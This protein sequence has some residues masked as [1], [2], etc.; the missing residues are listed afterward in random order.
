MYVNYNNDH[1]Q[2]SNHDII[3]IM[4]IF[5]TALIMTIISTESSATPYSQISRQ[6]KWSDNSGL[7]AWRWRLKSCVFKLEL[8]IK[9]NWSNFNKEN[10]NLQKQFQQAVPC[11]PL[12]QHQFYMRQL[13]WVHGSKWRK[14]ILKSVYISSLVYF[15]LFVFRFRLVF[16]MKSIWALG[17]CMKP[18]YTAN[19]EHTSAWVKFE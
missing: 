4:N 18:P 7:L 14:S 1:R 11:N 10:K 5:M 3:I 19:T 13:T 15:K 8:I 12:V 6:V 16:Q 2:Y 9:F 17:D